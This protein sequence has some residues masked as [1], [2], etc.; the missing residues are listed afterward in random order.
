MAHRTV[1][2]PF[3]QRDF[4]GQR[5]LAIHVQADHAGRP[6]VPRCEICGATFESPADLKTHHEVAHRSGRS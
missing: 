6:W 5:A 1:T 2:C 3:C 4:E